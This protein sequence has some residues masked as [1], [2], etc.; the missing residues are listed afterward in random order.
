VTG[1]WST[2]YEVTAVV[3]RMRSATIAQP[4]NAS[5]H[6]AA[7]W[8]WLLGAIQPCFDRSIAQEAIADHGQ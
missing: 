7:I 2:G 5:Y 1:A 3:A 8:P 4:R 6:N